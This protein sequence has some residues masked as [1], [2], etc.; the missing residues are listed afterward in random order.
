MTLIAGPNGSGKSTTLDFLRRSGV[1]T[2]NYFNA[3]VIAQGLEGTPEEIARRS[4]QVV[5]D[6]REAAI[7]SGR[8]LT[9]ETVMSHPSHVDA[10]HRARQANFF[11]RLIFVTTDDPELNVRR[12]ADRVAKGG[13]DVPD[14]K[15]RS[16]YRRI[17]DGQL[18]NAIIA[19]DEALLFDTTFGDAAKKPVPHWVGH[20]MGFF[21][22]RFDARGLT[23]AGQLERDMREA[24]GFVF[25]NDFS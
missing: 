6:A 23:W 25:P 1:E 5:R 10:I 24:G 15:I 16:R 2:P 8:S 20:I 4:Q 13:H 14:E 12:V 18:L 17:F 3:D 11:V 7:L 22:D 19:A 21:V 9:Y